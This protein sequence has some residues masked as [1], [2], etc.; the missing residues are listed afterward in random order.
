MLAFDREERPVLDEIAQHP[1]VLA[2]GRDASKAR[3]RTSGKGVGQRCTDGAGMASSIRSSG[4]P[5]PHSSGSSDGS[6]GGS[7]IDGGRR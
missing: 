2:A 4:S 6:S 7:S 3:A 1:W 5:Y